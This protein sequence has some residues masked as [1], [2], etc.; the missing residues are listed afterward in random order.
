[1]EKVFDQPRNADGSK[2]EMMVYGCIGLRSCH[3]GG[4]HR[5]GIAV[6]SSS[7]SRTGCARRLL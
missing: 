4:D 5:V 1:M 3:S 6:R 2:R 7:A